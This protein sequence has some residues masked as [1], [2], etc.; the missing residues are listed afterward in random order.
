MTLKLVF[1]LH[2]RLCRL[3]EA[4]NVIASAHFGTLIQ[5]SVHPTVPVLL[6]K[7]NKK[8][9]KSSPVN[10]I[11]QAGLPDPKFCKEPK[12]GPFRQSIC[13]KFW[14]SNA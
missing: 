8:L 14:I 6:T 1:D 11:F 7:R 5:C 13:S 9:S 2:G 12:I 4:K 10:E 3:L